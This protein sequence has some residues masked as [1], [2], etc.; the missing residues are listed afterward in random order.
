VF[1]NS[2]N[3]FIFSI[4]LLQ[5]L[6]TAPFFFRPSRLRELKAASALRMVERPAK[7]PK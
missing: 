5:P 6:F 1:P 2:E 3:P 7:I 4:S